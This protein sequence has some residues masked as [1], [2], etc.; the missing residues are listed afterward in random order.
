[1]VSRN[2]C[3]KGQLSLVVTVVLQNHGRL[4]QLL[5][6]TVVVT[7]A[8]DSCYSLLAR[9]LQRIDVGRCYSFNGSIYS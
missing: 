2:N 7:A 9:L 4:N 1:M 3:C 8:L 5:Q 6:R